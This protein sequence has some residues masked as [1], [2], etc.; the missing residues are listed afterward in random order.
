[1]PG[2][3]CAEVEITSYCKRKSQNGKIAWIQRKH[4][5]WHPHGTAI[6]QESVEWCERE[7][8]IPFIR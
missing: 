7:I 5:F 4:F 8:C 1:M 3:P 6:C 2:T